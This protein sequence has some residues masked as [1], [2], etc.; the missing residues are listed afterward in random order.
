MNKSFLGAEGGKASP[1]G[2]TA[3]GKGRDVSGG[4]P[5]VDTGEQITEGLP[6]QAGE[7][8]LTLRTA[9]LPVSKSP[10][11]APAL[12]SGRPE[13]QSWFLHLKTIHSGQL[14]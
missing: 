3:L 4:G 12:E 14:R 10:Y 5:R 2:G 7:P 9:S 6:C 8:D 13:F 11:E 1:G